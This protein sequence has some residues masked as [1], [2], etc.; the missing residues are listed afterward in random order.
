MATEL[1]YQSKKFV[2]KLG[3]FILQDYVFWL[4]KGYAK[5]GSWE[6]TCCSVRRLYEEIHQVRIIARDIRDLD[7]PAS[8]AALV[9]WATHG[10]V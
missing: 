9:L 4:A 6:L 3:N 8:T 1:L 2:N 10:R 5:S 7:D